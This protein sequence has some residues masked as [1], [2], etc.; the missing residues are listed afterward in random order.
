MNL[1]PIL[2]NERKP[3]EVRNL[4]KY[5]PKRAGFSFGRRA[6]YVRA[7]YAV[8][9]EVEKG[10][11]FGLVGESGSGKTTCGK[12]LVKLLEPSAGEILIDGESIEG[13]AGRRLKEFRRSVQMIFQD[14]YESLNPRFTVMQTVAEP[15]LVQG[16]SRRG[17]IE[18]EVLGTLESVELVPPGNFL[19]RFPHELSGGQRQRVAIA[20]ALVVKPEFIVAD[21]PVSMLDAS[22]RAGLLNLML[23]LR[24]EDSLTYLF[25]TH[26]LSVARY[27]CDE[28][29]V[30]YLGKLVE[31][32]ETEEIIQ[33]AI[34]PYSKALLSA[35][36]TPDPRV[37]RKRVALR[38]EM[39]DPA[40]P[41]PGCPFHPRC[42]YVMPQ[43]K[44]VDPYLKYMGH[45]HMVSC[46]LV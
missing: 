29:A 40:S 26:D 4:T 9:F 2:P 27:I 24:E 14:P 11:I 46:H 10:K 34:H 35:V 39:P 7:V 30:M 1:N 15:L 33:N 22:I 3:I 20:R 18:K 28:I 6:G 5:F 38:G 8:S 12:L 43:C 37:K 23:K 32:A 19:T 17:E 44:E 16:M 13:M 36:P 25:I 42:Q 21:E 45:G 41:P 31:R